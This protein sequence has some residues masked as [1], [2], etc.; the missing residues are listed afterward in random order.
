[1]ASILLFTGLH[2]S[3]VVIARFLNHQQYPYSSK[4]LRY[5]S[6]WHLILANQWDVFKFWLGSS[7]ASSFKNGETYWDPE[8]PTKHYINYI[9]S[10][11]LTATT[12]ENGCMHSMLRLNLLIQLI[13]LQGHHCS[14]V[15]ADNSCEL[16]PWKPETTDFFMWKV[17]VLKNQLSKTTHDLCFLRIYA[18]DEW[19]WDSVLMYLT[20]CSCSMEN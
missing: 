15:E 11:K 6:S 5:D 13:L 1:M 16:L 20:F 3:Q 2:A 8:T 7:R 9:P 4:F 18:V 14:G 10:L 12:P 17:E 19:I